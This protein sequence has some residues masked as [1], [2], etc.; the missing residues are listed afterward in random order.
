MF[1]LKRVQLLFYGCLDNTPSMKRL[2]I[3]CHE[4]SLPSIIQKTNHTPAWSARARPE[5]WVCAGSKVHNLYSVGRKSNKISLK[6]PV[7]FL[8]K[9]TCLVIDKHI[10]LAN[11]FFYY[12]SHF[13]LG[14]QFYCFY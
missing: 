5:M 2:F 13:N 6:L 12:N 8:Y 4:S 10:F 9:T 14:K 1:F 11:N 7:Y 3:V